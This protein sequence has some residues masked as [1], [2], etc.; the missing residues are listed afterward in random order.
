VRAAPAGE[1]RHGAAGA[2]TPAAAGVALTASVVAIAVAGFAVDAYRH[3]D[4]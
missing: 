3:R 1:A 2:T 4:R